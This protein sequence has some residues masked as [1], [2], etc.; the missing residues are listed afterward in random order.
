[1]NYSYLLTNIITSSVFVGLATYLIQRYIDKRFNKIEE[2]QKTLLTVRKE[3][4]DILLKTMQ[5]V[6]A[7]IIEVEYYIRH[8]LNRQME[9]A[10]TNTELDFTPIKD[11][12]V[13]IEKR[14]IL[15]SP[16]LSKMIRELFETYFQ[17]TF[18]GYIKVINQINRKEK[19]IKDLDEYILTALGEKYKNDLN[20]LRKMFEEQSHKILYDN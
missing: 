2:F 3:R 18:N 7:Q 4:Y 5:E 20:N 17:G 15:L 6:W 19:T 10:K 1:M 13:C 8:D 12:F 11:A 9:H 16:L 14:N